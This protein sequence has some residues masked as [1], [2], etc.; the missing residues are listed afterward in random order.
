MNVGLL[1]N[2]NFSLLIFGKL[3]SLIGTQMQN[4]SLSLYVLKTTGS[5]AKFASVLAV[6]I[7]P[8]L[9][10]GPI[11]GVL[12]DWFDRKKIMIYLNVFSGLAV[13]VCALM[14]KINGGLSMPYIYALVIT[15]SIIS[16]LYVPAITTV[17]PTVIKKEELP[18]A[19]GVNAFI[20]NLGS[21]TA[22]ALAGVL[23]GLY[24]MFIILIVNSAS[25][26]IAAVSQ[27]FIKMPKL[28]KKP[29]KIN[30]TTF[31]TDFME[32]V[33]FIKNKR[34]ILNIIILGMII[35]FALC[36][37]LALWLLVLA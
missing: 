25:F 34:L 24:S 31:S 3:A 27:I 33:K 16:L 8:Q 17:I 22:P 35:N 21:L 28:N 12:A 15:L 4:F 14:F 32:G 20:M 18:D 5:A 19:N 36:H 26:F 11:A 37:T 7:V 10:L 6:T 2:K 29:E 23:F 1:K 30:F 13:G 9:L